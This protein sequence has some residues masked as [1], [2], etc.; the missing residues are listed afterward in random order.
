M[1]QLALNFTYSDIQIRTQT[2]GEIIWFVLKDVCDA[3]GIKNS[4]DV[5]A[6]LDDDEKGV[7]LIDTLGGMQNMNTVNEPGLYNVILRSDSEKAKPFRRWVTHEV[8][9]S[10]RKQGYYSLMSDEQLM[11]TLLERPQFREKLKPAELT[12]IAKRVRNRQAQEKERAKID[13]EYRV[14][15]DNVIHNWNMMVQSAPNT[16]VCTKSAVHSDAS[17]WIGMLRN[18]CA[19][20]PKQFEKWRKAYEELQKDLGR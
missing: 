2:D 9:P 7:A 14:H 3:L 12:K 5:Y 8:L 18:E 15:R 6:R 17:V 10:I 19:G 20:N 13:P 1:N 16:P 4:R 11:E